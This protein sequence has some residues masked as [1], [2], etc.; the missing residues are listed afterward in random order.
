MDILAHAKHLREQ[1][2]LQKKIKQNPEVDMT[3]FFEEQKALF[4]IEGTDGYKAIVKFWEKKRKEYLDILRKIDPSDANSIA[5]AQ[6]GYEIS[7]SFIRF[8][9][10][11]TR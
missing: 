7:D 8:I 3:T 1:K 5:K 9:K 10:T 6:A 2:E 4:A 11:R